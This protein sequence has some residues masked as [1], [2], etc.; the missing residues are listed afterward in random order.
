M[1]LDLSIAWKIIVAKT[2]PF[3]GGILATYFLCGPA[4]LWVLPQAHPYFVGECCFSV[5]EGEGSRARW[6]PWGLG[7]PSMWRLY[8]WPFWVSSSC[9]LSLATCLGSL[10]LNL[11][12]VLPV[13]L[14]HKPASL[15]GYLNEVPP[16][17]YQTN[18]LKVKDLWW[19][20]NRG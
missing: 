14:D 19:T 2:C 20:L 4:F 6:A 16:V 7:R 11:F 17:C 5:E 13:F 10:L 8:L 3:C 18:L 9:P 12:P 1:C 15:L